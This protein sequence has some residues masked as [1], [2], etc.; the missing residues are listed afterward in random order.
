MLGEIKATVLLFGGIEVDI[1][2]FDFNDHS[3]RTSSIKT[4]NTLL[5]ILVVSIVGLRLF[6]RAAFVRK[7]FA[8]DVLILLATTFT[9]ALASTCLS[10]T[11]YGLGTHVWKLPLTTIIQTMK[12]CI[13]HLYICQVLYAFA[14]ALTKI[15]IISSYLRFIQNR[16]FRMSM[17]V[18][19]GVI[20]GLWVTGVFVTIFQC[21]PVAGAWDFTLSPPSKCVNYVNYLYASSAV[22]ILTD[23][24]L[25]I[26][27]WPHLWKLKMPLKQR[28]TLCVLFAGGISACIVCIVRIGYLHHL[29]NMD[30]TYQS[31]PALNL[32]VCEC[33][34]GIICISIP[35]LRPIAQRIF[36]KGLRTT[37]SSK[38]P[39]RSVPLSHMTPR[40]GRST[41]DIE[42]KE[43]LS[44]S[45]DIQVR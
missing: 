18:I 44:V 21:S 15:A 28:I 43:D 5:I 23:I 7:I 42:H 36:P 1:S 39:S 24:L 10:A 37:S 35:A 3:S 6:A 31:V 8:D 33:S 14:I 16:R 30:T 19:S 22:N 11:R 20:A 38:A 27:P 12:N 41:F 26:L 45:Q 13:L 2:Q 17:Y 40:P 25:C 32:T 29:R 4:T 9:V 34:L